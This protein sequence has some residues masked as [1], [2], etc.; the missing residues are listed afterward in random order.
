M[1][2]HRR[3]RR[4]FSLIELLVTITVM[5]LL[6]ML[7]VPAMGSWVADARVRAT[8]ESLQSALHL[9]QS[10]AVARS[11]SSV[12]A[13]TSAA[14]AWNATPAGN[15]SNWF[16]R[17]LPMPDSDDAAGTDSFVQG[18]TAASQYGV[19]LEGPALL[20]FNALGQLSAKS[21]SATGMSA[22]CTAPATA[23]PVEY[24]L[25]RA[26]GSRKLKLRVD[27]GGKV[28]MCD[29]AKSLSNGNPDGC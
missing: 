5:A 7:A 6:T 23:T 13:L 27:L 10:T 26:G 28:R 17:L 4:G 3:R 19:K 25:S 9:A 16:V 2:T 14:P 24:T 21:A 15:G 29:A 22:A 20:C 18:S 8:A 12:L 1:L 11:R